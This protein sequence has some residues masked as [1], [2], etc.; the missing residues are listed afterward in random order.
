[1]KFFTLGNE[2][3]IVITSSQGTTIF[4]IEHIEKGCRTGLS[5]LFGEFIENLE[6]NP[7][8]SFLQNTDFLNK[9][10]Y[11]VVGEIVYRETEKKE[12]SKTTN[13]LKK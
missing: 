9:I 13:R 6:K 1:V 3:L 11:P 10:Y 2:K 8:K 5:L 4:Y 12:L 7:K